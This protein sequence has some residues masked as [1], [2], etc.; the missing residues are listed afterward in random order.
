MK[1]FIIAVAFLAATCTTSS[2]QDK[3]QIASDEYSKALAAIQKEAEA[4]RLTE[5][6]T[7]RIHAELRQRF[8]VRDA[9]EVARSD[10]LP[11]KW[12]T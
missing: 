3:D 12:S 2:G 7:R 1:Q 4:G 5:A 10:L 6:D 8:G 9:D 11:I